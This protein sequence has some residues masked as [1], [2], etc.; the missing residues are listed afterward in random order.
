MSF[1]HS[2]TNTTP[3]HHTH[4]HRLAASKSGD[5]RHHVKTNQNF[6]TVYPTN[7]NPLAVYF[8]FICNKTTAG[9]MSAVLIVQ[10]FDKKLND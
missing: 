3:H 7:F 1:F 5:Y 2:F 10:K 6:K 4:K 9:L 8:C